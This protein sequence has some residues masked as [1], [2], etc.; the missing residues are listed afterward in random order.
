[1][2]KPMI[3]TLLVKLSKTTT[4]AVGNGLRGAFVVSAIESY[5]RQVIANSEASDFAHEHKIINEGAWVE[6]AKQCL[7]LIEK[8]LHE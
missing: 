8:A 6:C 1:M 4:D 5:S 2:K 7:E 3:D